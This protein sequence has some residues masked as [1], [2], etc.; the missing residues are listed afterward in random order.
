MET[1]ILGLAI[2]MS[3]VLMCNIL[4]SA[5]VYI[6]DSEVGTTSDVFILAAE[7]FIV[8]ACWAFYF[9]KF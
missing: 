6:K 7:M 4:N 8:S 5:L 1:F 2:F 3:I 9:T